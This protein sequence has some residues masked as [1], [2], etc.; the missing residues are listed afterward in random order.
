MDKN[1]QAIIIVRAMSDHKLTKNLILAVVC[2][3]AIMLT[4]T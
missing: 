2:S 4:T 3:L 1:W